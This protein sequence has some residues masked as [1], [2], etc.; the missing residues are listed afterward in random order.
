MT[1]GKHICKTLK[2]I[3]LLVAKANEIPYAP[4]ECRHEG[5]CMGTCPKCESEV[6]Y[7]EQ[8]LDMRRAMGKAVSLVGVGMGV[9]ALSSCHLVRTVH[10][11]AGEVANEPPTTEVIQGMP[12]IRDIPHEHTDSCSQATAGMKSQAKSMVVKEDTTSSEIIFGDIDEQQPSFRGGNQALKKFIDTNLQY[13]KQLKDSVQGR[14]II[15]FMILRDGS[16][17]DAKV[18]KSLHPLL[19]Q[20]ALRVVKMMPKW[21]P[22]KTNGQSVVTRYLLPITFTPQ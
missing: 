4:T 6:R 3:R 7:L 1:I 5:D 8:Q 12:V 14:A 21:L 10:P 2:E 18:V 16:I 9:A 19:D 11:T 20:E 13:P 22:G 17:S 15:S